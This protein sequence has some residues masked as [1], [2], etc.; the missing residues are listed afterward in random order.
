MRKLST[1]DKLGALYC[2]YN[3]YLYGRCNN[4]CATCQLRSLHCSSIRNPS[5]HELAILLCPGLS[6]M[7]IEDNR[8]PLGSIDDVCP[9]RKKGHTIKEVKTNEH[10][11]GKR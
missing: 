6:T 7:P 4:C 8:R 3:C 5:N 2:R 9:L 1:F 10:Q 11:T